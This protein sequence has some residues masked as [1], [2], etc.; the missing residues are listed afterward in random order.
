MAAKCNALIVPF[1][2]LGGDEAF[3]LSMDSDEVGR[4]ATPWLDVGYNRLCDLG[5][6]CKE[7]S[8]L[9]CRALCCRHTGNALC[10]RPPIVRP[11]L[12]SQ[13]LSNPLL[14]PL[15]RG[16]Y[17]RYAPDMKVEETVYPITRMPGRETILGS[18]KKKGQFFPLSRTLPVGLRARPTLTCVAGP[19]GLPSLLPVPSR[20]ERLYYKMQ[21]PI[22]ARAELPDLKDEKQ[23]AAL[24]RRV[25][26][27]ILGGLEELREYRRQDPA[28][29]LPGRIAQELSAFLPDFSLWQRRG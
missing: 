28:A 11:A 4:G 13:I 21:P 15:V 14:G 20:L 23:A 16:L 19:L 2:A 24:Y 29:E 26:Q 6:V 12:P 10:R 17:S 9:P 7:K 3:D 27:Q 8:A 22:D 5:H 25:Q 18:Q 1:A